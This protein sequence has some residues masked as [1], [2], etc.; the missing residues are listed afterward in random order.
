MR[1][2]IL[3]DNRRRASLPEAMQTLNPF[4][5]AEYHFGHGFGL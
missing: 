3:F 5:D 1:D 2:E 4:T